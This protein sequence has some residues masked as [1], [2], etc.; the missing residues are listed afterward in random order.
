MGWDAAH[1][2]VV[3]S[4]DRHGGDKQP[5]DDKLWEELREEVRKIVEQ[6][7]YKVIHAQVL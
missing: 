1:L 7:K 5:L 3:A 6:E 2:E 4:L